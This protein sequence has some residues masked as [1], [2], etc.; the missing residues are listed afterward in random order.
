MCTL[1]GKIKRYKKVYA[2][3]HPLHKIEGEIR[4]GVHLLILGEKA[5][6]N[7]L[8]SNENAYLSGNR[9][10]AFGMDE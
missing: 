5:Q 8:K 7:K 3:Y 6:E 10:E 9:A 2:A 1:E 4:K